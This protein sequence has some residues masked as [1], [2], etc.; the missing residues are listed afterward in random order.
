MFYKVVEAEKAPWSWFRKTEKQ[1]THH[2]RQSKKR[3]R[4]LNLVFPHLLASWVVGT[5]G[6]YNTFFAHNLRANFCSINRSSTLYCVKYLACIF[7]PGHPVKYTHVEV[8][9][10]FVFK[11]H[12]KSTL[13][14][15]C[16]SCAKFDFLKS[17]NYLPWK[18]SKRYERF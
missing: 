17:I 2:W 3:A 13:Q 4:W 7:S 6:Q 15:A 11:S 1:N 9:F 8:I 5:L 16:N 14:C 10:F 12:K 18:F